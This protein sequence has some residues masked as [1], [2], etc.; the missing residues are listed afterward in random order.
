[1]KGRY[2]KFSHFA[3]ESARFFVPHLG[4]KLTESRS[5][6]KYVAA[7][8]PTHIPTDTTYQLIKK[9]HN[10]YPQ[11]MVVVI[12]D[13][14]PLTEQNL[15]VLNKISKL[16][17][18]YKTVIS[19]RTP[20]NAL[21]AGALNF[22]IEYLSKLK[23]KPDVVITFDDDV[24]I[25]QETIPY[26]V[27][28]LYSEESV[29]AVCSQVGVKNK[30]KNLLTRLQA[31]EYHSFN[32]TKISDNGFLK[33][34]LVMQGMLTAFRMPAIEAVEGFTHGH[35]I[36]D[37]DIT[38]R[39]KTLGMKVKI[40]RKAIAWTHVPETIEDLWKQRVR[41]TS[42]GLNVLQEF[43]G[44]TTVVYQDMIGHTLFLSLLILIGLSFLFPKD[45]PE[46]FLAMILLVSSLTNFFIAFSF[47]IYSLFIYPSRDRKDTII[48]LTILPELIYSN[49]LSLV[50]VGSYLFFVYKK[51]AKL[52]E[53]KLPFLSQ[54]YRW[55]LHVF[56]KAG[57]STTWG[58]RQ[59]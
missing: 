8:I 12:D 27:H 47:N 13:C 25:N 49:M 55:G 53:S 59:S 5:Y 50:L 10:W 20:K 43:W 14:T 45:S 31:L 26:M 56:N 29:G 46:H 42:G 57:F 32:M 54:P 51:L 41:W 48:K 58:T 15:P 38:A 33:G 3:V 1:M 30:N 40:A 37:Y 21:K 19:L 17:K 6:K 52:I 9:L 44:S 34:P 11:M 36:E 4:T 39:L 2:H 24:A 16:A 23:T 28:S 22:G 35:L 18:E 7:V